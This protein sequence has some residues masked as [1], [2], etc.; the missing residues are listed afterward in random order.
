MTCRR[1]RDRDRLTLVLLRLGYLAT[2]EIRQ[3]LNRPQL[4]DLLQVAQEAMATAAAFN[5]DHPRCDPF[6]GDDEMEWAIYIQGECRRRLAESFRPS[7]P[8]P[9]D[10]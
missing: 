8:E 2:R 5:R 4:A 10:R 3:P 9:S 1:E 7:R 6:T